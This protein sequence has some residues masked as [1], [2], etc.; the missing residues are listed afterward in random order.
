MLLQFVDRNSELEGLNDLYEKEGSDLFVLYGR[1]RIGKTTLCKKFSEDKPH[2]YFLA[3]KQDFTLELERL[4]ETFSEQKDVFIPD[5]NNLEEL[6]D[7]ILKKVDPENKFVFIIDEFPYWIEENKEIL[8]EMQ[9]LWDESLEDENIFLLLTG[10][11]I[12]MMESE[13]LGYKSPIYGRRTGQLRLDE[14]PLENLNEFFPNYSKEDQIRTY[15]ALGG[16]PYYLKEFDSEKGFFENVRYTFLNK[17]NIL[18]EEAE[19]LLREELRKPNVYF[20]MIKAIIDGA[21][22]LSE[23]S[24]KSKISITNVNKYLKVLERLKIIK[25]EYPITEPAKKK[26]FHYR[27]TDS[28]FRF[29]LSFVYPHQGRIEDNP[30]EI[31]EKIKGEYKRYMGLVFE[32]ICR[33]HVLR[34]YGY[35]DV[36]RW[37]YKED[38]IDIVAINEKGNDILF[39]ECKWSKNEVGLSDLNL[40][41]ERSEKV[42]W[43]DEQ[44]DESFILF[45]KSG[46]T[47]KLEEEEQVRLMGLEEL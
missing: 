14:L 39:G 18:H 20:N 30:D 13:V 45:S 42:R 35:E 25:R 27:V 37:W 1:R 23:I 17:L 15:G 4:R 19:I 43:G 36:G 12:G 2:F 9:H 26:N 31:L 44:R 40:L 29:W 28:Y 38:E 11:S 46:F 7:N 8:S 33:D 10:S 6:F 24:N 47:Q 34:N 32:E 41:K 16:V 3:R 5:V 22:K 21:T